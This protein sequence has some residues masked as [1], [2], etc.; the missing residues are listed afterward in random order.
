MIHEKG[1]YI[2]FVLPEEDGSVGQS[3]TYIVLKTF[4]DRYCAYLCH[5]KF[6]EQDP[7]GVYGAMLS[8]DAIYDVAMKLSIDEYIECNN[9]EEQDAVTL[10]D[11]G[12][13]KGLDPDVYN[14]IDYSRANDIERCFEII[15]YE[16][17]ITIECGEYAGCPL[18]KQS[19]ERYSDACEFLLNLLTKRN[20]LPKVLERMIDKFFE[21]DDCNL[22]QLYD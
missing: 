22:E 15:L 21:D 2:E 20:E 18:T 19:F 4:D 9:N 17:S 11:F 16:G 8:M 3:E 12:D 7:T 10:I 5:D 14:L 13:C 6:T 1:S